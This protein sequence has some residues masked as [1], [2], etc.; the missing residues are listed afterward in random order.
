MAKQLGIGTKPLAKPRSIINVDGTGNR[1]GTLTKY[2]DLLVS[3]QDTSEVQRLFITNLGEDR[4]I[5]GFPWLQTFSPDVNWRQAKITGRT[6]VRTTQKPPPHWAQI[7]QLAL[8]ARCIAKK[9]ELEE[10]EEVHIRINK[11]N[12]AQQ[13]AEKLLSDKKNK[14]MMEATIPTQYKEYSDVFSESAAR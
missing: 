5:F 4:A 10:G 6:V 12:V 7:S 3:H 11:T 14:L 1:E 8:I 9:E 13:W 2:A